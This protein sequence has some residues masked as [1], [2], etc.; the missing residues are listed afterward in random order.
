MLENERILLRSVADSDQE[1]FQKVF[2]YYYPKVRC[3][4]SQ[5]ISDTEEAKDIAQEIFVKIWLTRV[6][7]PDIKSFGAYIYTITRNAAIDFGRRK[8]VFIPLTEDNQEGKNGTEENEGGF[9][10][11]EM[12]I[13]IAGA[14]A[15]MPKTRKKVFI[16]S[17]VEGKTNGEIAELLGISKKTV[18]NHINNALKQLRKLSFVILFFI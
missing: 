2:E 9:F 12:E 8:K 1:A 13:Q 6:I 17:R 7:L 14:V 3:F 16:L 10:A 5:F 18:E 11:K 4:L 15:K